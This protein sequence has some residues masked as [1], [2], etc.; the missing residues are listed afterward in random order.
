M[1][2]KFI[3][4][5]VF[6]RIACD[7]VAKSPH[8]VDVEFVPMLAHV[9][10]DRLHQMIADRIEAMEAS[11]RRYDALILG[12]G[13]CGNATIGLSCSIPMIIPRMHDCCT[14]F[15]GS[16]QRFLE[17][18]KSALSSRWCTT[19]YWERTFSPNSGYPQLDQIDNYKTT[20]EYMNLVDQ[21]DEETAEYLWETMHPKIEIKE[22][23]YIKADGYE[24]SGAQEG[25]TA[26]C[27]RD[28]VSVN[29]VVGSNELLKA[30]VDGQWD[31]ER[32]LTVQPGQRVVGV[33]D[34]DQVIRA[35]D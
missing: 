5:D 30:L 23:V 25:F 4:C 10:P 29:V 6:A 26:F 17:T 24:F 20:A 15:M 3:C 31:D 2:I 18:F 13:L 1:L 35:G 34:M 8:V 16:K 14:A 19:G 11:D 22:A 12:F 7:L 28:E 21:Y 9:E 33:Y 32:F 27:Q